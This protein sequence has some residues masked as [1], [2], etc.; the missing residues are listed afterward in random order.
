VPA[1]A[2]G[3]PV[4]EAVGPPAEET[5]PVTSE[6]TALRG[7][8][9]LVVVPWAEVYV[10]GGK[11]GV[12][13]PLKPLSLDPGVHDVKLT[14]PSYLP[15]PRRVTIRAGETTR[16]EVDLTKEAFRR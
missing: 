4:A 3:T 11:V 8:L 7:M 5:S 16:L 12:S 2:E 13:P 9:Q 1:E 10:D 6:K 14:H 15:L